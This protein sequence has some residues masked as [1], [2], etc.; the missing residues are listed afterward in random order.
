M[1]LDSGR[2]QAVGDPDE[3]VDLYEERW[4]TVAEA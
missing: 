1:P 3:I 2:I 4:R